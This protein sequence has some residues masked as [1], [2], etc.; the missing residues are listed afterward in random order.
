M[1]FS[2]TILILEDDPHSREHLE[3]IFSFL[4]LTCQVGEVSDCLS[5]L[6]SSPQLDI[7]LVGALG[8]SAEI[9]VTDLMAKYPACAF[10]TTAAVKLNGKLP[11][12]CIGTLPP[13]LNYDDIIT[14]LHYCQSFKSMQKFTRR[15][16]DKSTQ[17][18]K[19]LVGK[20]E[21]IT[22]VRR[23]IE[24]VA[25]TDANVL[26]LGESGTGKEVVARAIHEL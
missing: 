23:L 16:N 18:L 26:I 21:A 6:D 15:A 22:Q 2:G 13:N 10:I 17:L 19:L 14:L 7:C 12:N 20:G 25:G 8:S 11:S 3:T 5:Y 1:Q 24:Q 9:A 4:G